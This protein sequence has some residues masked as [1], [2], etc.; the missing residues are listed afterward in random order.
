MSHLIDTWA[1]SAGSV[2][3]WAQNITGH[4]ATSSSEMSL[5]SNF[6]NAAAEGRCKRRSLSVTRRDS[7]GYSR[8]VTAQCSYP[9]E[10]CAQGILC[11]TRSWHHPLSQTDILSAFYH[12]LFID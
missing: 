10:R 5:V 1:T 8:C 6:I 2:T 7:E 4:L 12:C 9:V 3:G 11:Y